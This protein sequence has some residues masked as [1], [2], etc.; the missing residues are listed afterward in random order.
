MAGFFSGMHQRRAERLVQ[1]GQYDAA[2]KAYRMA[3]NE[4]GVGDVL[5]LK[6]DH[7][8]AM[9][10]FERLGL[11]AKAARAALA[12]RDYASAARLLVAAGDVSGAVE[13]LKQG[14]EFDAAIRLC[15]DHGL[16]A[17]AAAIHLL[18]GQKRE[19]GTL[20]LQEGRYAE[21][22][23]LFRELGDTERLV[24]A[25]RARGD[26]EA[27]AQECRE[28]GNMLAAA[29]LYELAGQFGLAGEMFVAAGETSRATVMFEQAGLHDRVAALW[30]ASGMLDLAAAAFE[31]MP[32]SEGSAA[33]LYQ[34]LVVLQPAGE[35]RTM[36]GVVISGAMAVGADALALGLANRHVLFG[37]RDFKMKWQFRLSGEQV[38]FALALSPD[39]S[40]VAIG[41]DAPAGTQSYQLIVLRAN[42]EVA[43]QKQMDDSVKQVVFL[44]DGQS[45]LAACSDQ[46][47]CFGLDGSVRW[48]TAVD[49]HARALDLSPEGDR[50]AVGSLGGQLMV[51]DTEGKVLAVQEMHDR[52]HRVRFNAEA[53]L[54]VAAAGDDHLL[55]CDAATLTPV[56][57]LRARGLFR[58]LECLPG[59]QF[60]VVATGSDLSVLNWEGQYLSLTPTS[61]TVTALFSDPFALRVYVGGDNA[62]LT[63][64]EPAYFSQKAA[65]LFVAAGDLGNAARIYEEIGMFDRAY[66]LYRQ[67]GEYEN[68]AR[69]MQSTGDTVRAARHYE[70]VGKYEQAARLYEGA[71]ELAL[72]ARCYGRAGELLKAATI[73]EKLGDLIL[74]AD[75]YEQTGDNKRAAVLYKQAAQ[76]ERAISNFEAW[77]RKEPEDHEA[78]FEL[79]ALYHNG[80]RHDEAIRML[81]RLTEDSQFKREALR[82]LGECFLAKRLPDVA[83]D[84]FNEALGGSTKP[85]RETLDLFYLIGR[86]HEMALRFNEAAEVFAK[87]MAIDYYY[88]DIQDRVSKT[89]QMKAYESRTGQARAFEMETSIGPTRQVKKDQ[90]YERY[91][92]LKKLGQ[93]GMGVVYLA[94]DERLGRQVA[95]KVLPSHLSADK[96]FQMRL[97]REARAV[98]AL[99]NPHIVAIYD[100]VTEANECYITMEYIDGYPLREKLRNMPQLPLPD[101]CRHG[102][103]IAEALSVAHRADVIHRDVKPENI[104]I[105]R[106]TGDVKMVDFGLARLGEDQNITREGVIAG[107]LAYM[108][109]EQIRAQKM[110]H[111]V[112][113]YA[114][115][116]ILYEMAAGK[117]PF[118]GDNILGQHLHAPVP[119]LL[120]A[121]PD[122]PPELA[123]LVTECLA[124][125]PDARPASCDQIMKRLDDLR[126]T[127]ATIQ[128]VMFDKPL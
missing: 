112:D 62:T 61:A 123:Q 75:F 38:P 84:R 114:L 101:L 2:I 51:L 91:R 9:Q 82:L 58:G 25:Y 56:H 97:L 47:T 35:P 76:T 68:A 106:A 83:I 70:V 113:I 116:V 63:A 72:A 45:V 6:G 102:R 32:G 109:P 67:L 115:G 17:E 104:M 13:A 85:T 3:G 48:E 43:F 80:E 12:G 77:L 86:A 21:A 30:E 105:V 8:G 64:Y 120:E 90:G 111:R 19:A 52:I 39:G 108:A 55:I 69:V 20:L 60:T 34:K 122:A 31:R 28:A 121:R 78:I 125:D 44:R 74:A 10:Q 96:E 71:N 117:L 99:A 29:R 54:L 66:D 27:G 33:R 5:M 73:F 57:E 4:E 65:E 103:E 41:T 26:L 15:H 118:S 49:F 11:T 23:A 18:R 53:T 37:T 127:A 87:V 16:R 110:D 93:G 89:Q 98:A 7:L 14:R 46:V 95:W 42:K 100:I 124:K 94:M 22:I 59:R 40:H 36:D 79:G 92:I 88:R 1:A 107:T 126:K 24:A 128:T 81:Q 119:D 50:I